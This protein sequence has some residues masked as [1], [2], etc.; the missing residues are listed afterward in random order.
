MLAVFV[1]FL[2][3]VIVRNLSGLMELAL[4]QYLRLARGTGFAITTVAKYL[5]IVVGTVVSLNFIGIDW[6][7][8]QWL[9]AALTVGL[10]F[11]LQEIFA[12]FVS[13]LIILFEKPI[14]INDVITIRDLTGTVTRIKTRAT[15]I[16]DWDRR[17]IIVPNKAFIT[18]QLINWSLTDTIIRVKLKIRVQLDA[19]TQLVRQLIEAAVA[20]CSSVLEEP[21]PSVFLI[22]ITDSALIYEVRV[23]VSEMSRRLPMTDALHSLLLARLRRHGIEIPHQKIDIDMVGGRH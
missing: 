7:R 16:L 1:V 8:A 15:T 14:R 13:G 5:V 2:T 17:E 21:S 6:A 19:D 3:T 9:V 11:G 22:E 23:F 20:D 12:N 4:L 18:E 10:G